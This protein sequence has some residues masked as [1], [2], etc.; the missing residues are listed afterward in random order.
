MLSATHAACIFVQVLVVLALIEDLWTSVQMET[1][2]S[3]TVNVALAKESFR[4]TH[5]IAATEARRPVE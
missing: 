4:R 1:T 5:S 3:Q 2:E